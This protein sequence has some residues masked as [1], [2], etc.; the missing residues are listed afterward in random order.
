MATVKT[1]ISLPEPLFDRA[2][3]V[4]HSL[5]ISRSQLFATAVDEFLKRHERRALLEAINRA[6]EDSPTPEEREQLRIMGRKQRKL[7]EGEW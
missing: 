7:L 3:A 4:A 5:N 1:A 6:Y 2:E